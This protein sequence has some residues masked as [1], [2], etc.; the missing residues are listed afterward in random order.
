MTARALWWVGER[1][2]ELRDEP[3]ADPG[4]DEVRV[5]ADYSGVSRGTESL[6]AAGRVPEAL[7]HTMRAPFQAGDFP[8]PVKYGYCSVGTVQ[9][10]ALPAGTPVFALYP[11]QDRYVVPVSAVH[12]LPE[13]LPPARAVLAANV[14]TALNV[15]WDG[16]IGPADDVTVVGAG[17]V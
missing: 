5:R 10:G 17:V 3:L 1:C 7:H 12:A 13:G 11:H 16:G 15:V 8:W 4:S 14:E 2:A 6:V 9:D